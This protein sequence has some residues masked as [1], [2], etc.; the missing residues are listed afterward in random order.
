[1]NLHSLKPAPEQAASGDDTRLVER[2]LGAYRRTYSE[3]HYSGQWKRIFKRYHREL[4]HL[5]MTGS[6]EEAAV[7]LRD[8]TLNYMGYGFS[9]FM[10][11]VG[12]N[13]HDTTELRRLSQA[14]GASRL[15]NPE[16]GSPAARIV[17]AC[18][19]F[20]DEHASA[21]A[22]IDRLDS[23][24]DFPHVYVRECG[25][26]TKRGLAWGRAFHA[27]YQARLLKGKVLEIGG[28]LGQTAYYAYRFGAIDYTIVDLPFT[29]LSQ[30]YWLGR[31]L[32]E[33]QVVLPGEPYRQHGIKLLDPDTFFAGDDQFEVA[34]NCDSLTELS[35]SIAARYAAEVRKRARRFISINHEANGF[36]VGQLLGRATTRHPYWMRD[37]YVEERYHFS[38]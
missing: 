1:M 28:G 27:I 21:D 38:E 9:T 35:E 13:H 30:G 19:D 8:P 34:F 12:A 10:D 2:L 4:H 7:Q 6:V 25:L 29:A 26:V 14:L 37:G 11:Q 24:I 31:A 16:R 22:I 17:R 33:D 32:G 5:F 15:P 3:R 18:R 23:R 20:L 36:T